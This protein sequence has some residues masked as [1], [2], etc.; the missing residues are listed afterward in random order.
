MLQPAA[1]PKFT[2]VD[3]RI[4]ADLVPP[5]HFLRQVV[6]VIDFERFRPTLAKGYLSHTGRP[7]HDP[8]L[9][10]KLSFLSFHCRLSDRAVILR[11]R[12]DV[13]FRWF[14]GL[15]STDPLPHHSDLTYFRK[16]HKDNFLSAFQDLLTIARDHPLVS[17]HLRIKDATHF[18][19]DCAQARPL[20]LAAQVRERLLHFAEPFFPDWVKQQRQLMQN[21]RES[22]AESS[23]EDRLA[24]RIE[25]LRSLK[26]QLLEMTAKLSA[27]QQKLA[28]YPKLQKGLQIAEKLLQDRAD[29]KAGARLASAV[30][31]DARLGKHG[32]FF[33]GY[34]L[35]LAM[36]PESELITAVNVLPGNAAGNGL[37]AADAVV[38]I[39]Q[40][41]KAQGND[42]QEISIDGAGHHGPTLRALSSPEGPNLEVTVP[43]PQ[44]EARKTFG[45]E[46]F[47]LHVLDNGVEELSCPAGE[48]T[49]QKERNEDD[50]AWRFNFR[51]SQCK[52]CPLRGEC[53]ENPES[54]RGRKVTKNDYEEEYRRAREKVGTEA[55]QETRKK[56]PKVERKLGEMARHHGHRRARYRGLPKV[57][58]QAALTAFVVNVKRMVKLLA[59]KVV[60][61]AGT[62]RAEGALGAS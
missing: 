41:E 8:I 10:F 35:D 49:R 12:T 13:A 55:Y 26:D 23:D 53:L 27:E 43:V 40:E 4:F 47:A 18:F 52:E 51:R 46:R 37:E 21:I 30:D 7:A 9:L 38:L 31:A 20:Q 28:D 54:K 2:E 11:A 17:D 42:V 5:D 33:L 19:A 59:A 14:L 58:I 39:E 48:K 25:F 16:R 15:S 24:A 45:P 29:P 1:A 50:T 34:V 6:A 22:T 56:H 44:P 36:D 57:K 3:Q 32:E 60:E 61:G 62:V